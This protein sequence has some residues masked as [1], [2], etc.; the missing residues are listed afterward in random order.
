[1]PR[2]R[3]DKNVSLVYMSAFET[4]RMYLSINENV[5]ERPGGDEGFELDQHRHC[6]RCGSIFLVL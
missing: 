6:S 4:L 5:A 3:V 1:M 2:C